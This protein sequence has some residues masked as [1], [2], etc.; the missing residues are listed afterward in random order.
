MERLCSG[1]KLV[2][3]TTMELHRSNACGCFAESMF[4]ITEG[5]TFSHELAQRAVDM[6]YER[7]P[8]LR[9]GTVQSEVSLIFIH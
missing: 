4:T 5:R 3:V 9:N 6:G 7:V 8:Q 1:E 2:V